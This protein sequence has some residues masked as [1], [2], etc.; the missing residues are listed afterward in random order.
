ME[1]S[2]VNVNKALN[3]LQRLFILTFHIVATSIFL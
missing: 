1:L 2:N 3:I